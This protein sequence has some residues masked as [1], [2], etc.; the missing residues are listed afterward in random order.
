VEFFLKIEWRGIFPALSTPCDSNGALDVESLRNEVE[1]SIDKGA[2]GV[3]ASIV[4]GEFYK[5]SDSER[6]KIYEITVDAANGKVP[7]LVGP[8]HS[9][10]E[11]VI[12]LAKFAENIGADGTVVLPPYF[13][14]VDGKASLCL[15]EHYS[16]IANRVNLP[17]MIQDRE[18]ASPY[19]SS[20][21]LKRLSDDF[22]NIVSVKLE[23]NRSWEKVLEMRELA[24]EVVLF[25]GMAAVNMYKELEVGVAGNIPDACLI[26]VLVEVYDSFIRGDVENARRRFRD[27]KVWLDFLRLHSLQNIEVEKETLRQRGVIESSYVRLPHGPLLSEEEKAELYR[28]QMDLDL[29]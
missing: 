15:Y 10:T 26:D 6:M 3:I 17:M 14:L 9:G 20:L 18:G 4:A 19:M 27:Y 8:S 5:F 12:Q 16:E 21:L 25:G 28:I 23:G 24:P 1:W 2:H 22:D 7:V 29:L 13:N 11:V